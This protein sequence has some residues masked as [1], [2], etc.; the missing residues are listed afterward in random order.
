MAALATT[1]PVRSLSVDAKDW[2]WPVG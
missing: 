1:V 2:G